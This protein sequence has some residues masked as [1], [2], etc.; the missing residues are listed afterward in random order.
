MS[1]NTKKSKT[2]YLDCSSGISGDMTVAALLDLGA[3][4]KVLT[5]ALDSLPLDGYRVE[6]TNVI[7][8]GLKACDFHVILDADHENH[9]HDM[10][11][12]HGEPP[13]SDD[14]HTHHDDMHAHSDC[15]YSN[16]DDV[17]THFGHQHSYHD[18][19]HSHSN[20]QHSNPDDMHSHSDNQHEHHA[21]HGRNL[22]D[23]TEI[24]KSGK[25]TPRALELALKIFHIIAEAESQV[26]GKSLQ[27]VH[28]HEVGAVDSIVDIA[29]VAVCVDNLDIRQ[30][31]IPSLT[32]GCGQVRCQHG[33]LPVPVPATTAIVTAYQL[34]LHLSSVRGE[35]VTPT[36]AA[37]AAALRTQEKL[38]EEFRILRTGLGAG[39]RNY[40]IAGVLRAMLIEDSGMEQDH[41]LM[42]ETNM[43]D[44]TGEAMGFVMEELLSHGALDVFYTPIYMKKHRPA[45]QLSV[46]CP[47]EKR[48][49]MEALIF[50]H[51]TTIGLRA[52][53]VQRTKLSRKIICLETPWGMADVKC[54]QFGDE[55]YYY[56]ESDSIFKLAQEN[57]LSFTEMY[58]EVKEYAAKNNPLL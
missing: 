43:D 12:L 36:G 28:F 9:D 56:P 21:P 20:G 22:Q 40:P 8:S 1:L 51:T 4:A 46:L 14:I 23:I 13:V 50:R 25:L 24:L 42:I 19:M 47:L 55:V 52:Y 35:L 7:K 57:Q 18:D 54:C 58:H 10:E 29:A 5:E 44:C 27:E 53:E 6:I 31:I 34:P 17:H 16:P 33:L 3:D 37:I 48:Q 15:Q 38:P 45:Y 39:K 11:Y 32:E 30:V 2:L 41:V 26:H 49:D